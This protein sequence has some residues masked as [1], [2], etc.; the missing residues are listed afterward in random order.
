MATTPV[1]PSDL[2]LIAYMEACRELSDRARGQVSTYGAAYRRAGELVDD[3][4]RL[5]GQAE[6]VLRLAVAAERAASTSWQEIGERLGVSRQ[7][8]HER[9]AQA[10]QAISDGALFPAREPAREGA[11]GWW[12]CPDGLQD[13]EA[14]V[15]GLDEWALRHREPTDPDR[16]EHPVSA[17]LRRREDLAAVEAIGVVTALARRIM[18]S[19]LPDGVSERQARRMLLERK[20]ETFDLVAPRESGPGARDARAQASEAFQE[21]VAW[22]R[23]DLERRLSVDSVTYAELEAYRFALDDR[24][25]A[26]LAFT[27]EGSDEDTGWFRWSIDAQAFEAEPDAPSRWLG[28]PWPVGV[29]GVDIDE[30]VAIDRRDGRQAVLAAAADVVQRTRATALA[31]ARS[32]LLGSLASDLAKGVGPF[33]PGGMAGPAGRD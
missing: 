18:D 23:D 1:Q 33:E 19:D 16:G 8:A 3:A 20:I 10:V 11:L 29:A 32:E 2:H 31:S 6:E 4:L 5:V 13:P 17:G 30:L 7:S 21:L 24:P 14:T 28:D 26:E 25:V 27:A 12:A 15:R 9:F 22:Y